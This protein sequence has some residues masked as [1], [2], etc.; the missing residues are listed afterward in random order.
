MDSCLNPS[1]SSYLLLAWYRIY[2]TNASNTKE[3]FLR[4]AVSSG[5]WGN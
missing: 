3:W 2:D 1:D 4:A 5:D